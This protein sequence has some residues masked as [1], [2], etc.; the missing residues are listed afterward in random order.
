M[1]KQMLGCEV[2]LDDKPCTLPCS[3]QR[4][5]KY[6]LLPRAAASADMSCPHGCSASHRSG[7]DH[8]ELLQ[9]SICCWLG[10]PA[11]FML[12]SFSWFFHNLVLL[13]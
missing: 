4:A 12:L 10:M 2:Q 6:R 3:A 5:S 8:R 9:I 7:S 13:N 11:H 1:V